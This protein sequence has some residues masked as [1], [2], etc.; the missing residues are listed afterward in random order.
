M[1]KDHRVRVILVIDEQEPEVILTSGS[2]YDESSMRS[3]CRFVW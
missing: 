3:W 2:T 1:L